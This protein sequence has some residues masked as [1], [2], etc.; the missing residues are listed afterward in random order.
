MTSYAQNAEDVVLAR[1]FPDKTDGFFVDVGANEPVHDSV[2]A[3][4]SNRGWTGV[5]IDPQV[6][7]YE[8]LVEARPR[9]TNLNIGVGAKPDDLI[10]YFVPD[11]H[12]MSTFSPQHAEMVRSMGY[13]TVERT[14]AVRPLDDV[15]AEHVGDRTVDFLKV[16]VEGLEHEVL[17]N[18]DWSRYRP[19]VVLVESSP[20][21]DPW[22]ERMIAA[23]YHRTLWDGI[24]LFFVRDEDVAELAHRLSQPA[25][26]VLDRFDPW[27]YLVQIDQA[28]ARNEALLADHLTGHLIRRRPSGVE[29]ASLTA[30]ADALAATLARRP[31]VIEH[32]G[33]PP[34][35]DIGP[36]LNWAANAAGQ[37]SEPQTDRLVPF[38]P[39]Y[40]RLATAPERPQTASDIVPTITAAVRVRTPESIRRKYRS[41]RSRL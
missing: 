15:F 38:V 10:F 39:L 11:A 36:V 7:C 24:N 21:V 40:R 19:R 25:T 2:T 17:G 4:F 13:R 28:Q 9:D 37:P 34:G 16:D 14:V 27:L 8:H 18:F 6:T 29:R 23:G 30:A 41:L 32:F 12:A 1:A 22:E 5:N 20:D 26:I 31:D 3:H 35:V 33:G